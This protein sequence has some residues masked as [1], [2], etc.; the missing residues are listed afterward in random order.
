M[1]FMTLQQKLK[2]LNNGF[3][4]LSVPFSHYWR[5]RKEPPFGAWAEQG[6]GDSYYTGNQK[7]EQII[8]GTADYYTKVEFDP[9][10]DEV[11]AMLKANASSWRLESVQ[12]EEET[13][14]I[15]FEWTWEV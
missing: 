14:L 1:I 11:Q 2:Q 12:Y 15:H 3:A 8:A 7:T 6:E 10:V 5:P 13:G 4:A 9:M